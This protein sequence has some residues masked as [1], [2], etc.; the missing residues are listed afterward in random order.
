MY[1]II[2]IYPDCLLMIRLLNMNIMSDTN[3]FHTIKITVKK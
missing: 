3:G 2:P 1:P